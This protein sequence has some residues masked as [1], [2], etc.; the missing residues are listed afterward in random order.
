MPRSTAFL[1]ILASLV[2]AC[3]S[4]AGPITAEEARRRAEALDKLTKA[5]AAEATAAGK[6]GVLSRTMK[7]EPAVDVRRRILEIATGIPGPE[8]EAFLVGLLEREED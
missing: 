8:R 3:V 5:L 1:T 2:L 7:D 4:S 6:F